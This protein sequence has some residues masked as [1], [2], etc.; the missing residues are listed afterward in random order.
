M[1]TTWLRV[2]RLLSSN[3]QSN[4]EGKVTKIWHMQYPDK[5]TK[6]FRDTEKTQSVESIHTYT[7]NWLQCQHF[8]MIKVYKWVLIKQT[9]LKEPL[10]TSTFWMQFRQEENLRG[11]E[12]RLETIP[13][14][15]EDKGSSPK[16]PWVWGE[17]WRGTQQRFAVRHCHV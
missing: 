2:I 17:G 14:Q 12:K 15:A 11:L 10:A 13:L 1:L 6:S 5:C 8:S 9:I 3:S 7:P 4:G 16:M